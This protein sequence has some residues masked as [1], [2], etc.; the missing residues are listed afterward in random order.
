MLAPKRTVRTPR[1]LLGTLAL[2]L[3]LGAAC[4]KGESTSTPEPADA[5][6]DVDDGKTRL[7]YPEGGFSVSATT[8]QTFTVSGGASGKRVVKSDGM[9]VATPI[10]GGK[11]RIEATNG[12]KIEYMAE[13]AFKDEVEEGK[14][15]IDYVARLTGAK[16]YAVI[17]RIG[18]VD[19]DATKALPENVARR[20]AAEKKKAS[21]EDLAVEDLEASSVLDLPPLPTTGLVEGE[22]TKLDTKEETIE[23]PGGDMP[24]EIDSTY[25]LKSIEDKDGMK[26]ATVD[27]EVVSSGAAELALG[28]GSTF[29]AFDSELTGT[30]WFDLASGTPIKWDA[31]NL[32]EFHVGEKTFEQ[33]QIVTS[34][35]AKQ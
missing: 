19:G 7:K 28:Q 5:L 26:V 3:S 22:V 33:N 35:Y 9:I 25:V 20:E 6:S 15:P 4:E 31:E 30:L 18:E 29:V 34:T 16:S 12:D 8:E 11:L 10:D 23:T 13:G 32:T 27:I 21:D 14:E 24:V 1:A 2:A 17:D